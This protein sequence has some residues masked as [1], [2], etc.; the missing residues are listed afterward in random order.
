MDQHILGPAEL[1]RH[2]DVEFSFERVLAFAE[3]HQVLGPTDF[4][5]QRLEF[6]VA[7]IGEIKLLLDR[8][9]IVSDQ[10]LREA[11]QKKQAYFEKQDATELS[12]PG[13]GEVIRFRQAQNE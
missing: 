11:A 10:D 1:S 6:F 12:D 5:N 9:N 13:R 7:V 3:N 2:A 8:Y 4:S